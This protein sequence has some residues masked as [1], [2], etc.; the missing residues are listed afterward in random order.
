MLACLKAKSE[1]Q[2][3]LL[4]YKVHAVIFRTA[5]FSDKKRHQEK[6]DIWGK[7][8]KQNNNNK[9]ATQEPTKTGTE[10]KKL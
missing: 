3:S 2:E 5:S 10:K 7:T 4:M 8:A 1:S 9:K 6:P